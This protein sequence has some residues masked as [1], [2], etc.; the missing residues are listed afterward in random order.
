MVALRRLFQ[1]TTRVVWITAK[2]KTPAQIASRI[3]VPGSET[4]AWVFDLDQ[5]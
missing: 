3:G 2:S 4:E 1:P 5:F